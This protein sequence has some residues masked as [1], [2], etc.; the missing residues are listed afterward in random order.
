MESK[1]VKIPHEA[2]A[3]I[4]REHAELVRLMEAFPN[5]VEQIPA[6]MKKRKTILDKVTRK[7]PTKNSD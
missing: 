7:I 5:D 2:V 1:K 4:I 6:W 3:R